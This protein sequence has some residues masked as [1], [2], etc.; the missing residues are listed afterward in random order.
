MD[1]LRSFESIVDRFEAMSQ[2]GANNNPPASAA[3]TTEPVTATPNP[4]SNNESLPVKLQ[5]I[6]DFDAEQDALDLQRQLTGEAVPGQRKESPSEPPRRI[7]K[8]LIEPN[9]KKAKKETDPEELDAEERAVKEMGN[10]NWVGRLQSEFMQPS[11]SDLYMVT[12]T[13]YDHPVPPH[14]LNKVM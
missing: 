14:F 7:P 2:N 8:P 4:L 5:S 10:A 9:R 1:D 11:S 3:P 6:E 12:G 13:K